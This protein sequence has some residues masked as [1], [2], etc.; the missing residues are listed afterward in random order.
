MVEIEGYLSV[1]NGMRGGA[2]CITVNEDRGRKVLHILVKQQ[3]HEANVNV[4]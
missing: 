2:A 1:V 4:V 3:N